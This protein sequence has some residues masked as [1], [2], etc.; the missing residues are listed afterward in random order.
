MEQLICL[1]ETD[2]LLS[3]IIWNYLGVHKRYCE[4]LKTK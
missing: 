1:L 3:V 4:V 2:V